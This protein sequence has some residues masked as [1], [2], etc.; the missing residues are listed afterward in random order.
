MSENST[1]LR[2]RKNIRKN[3]VLFGGLIVYWRGASP[4][5]GWHEWVG[6]RMIC[7]G[8][9]SIYFGGKNPEGCA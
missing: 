6:G 9:W 4:Q 1:A 8:R 3:I 7:L 2:F 5:W